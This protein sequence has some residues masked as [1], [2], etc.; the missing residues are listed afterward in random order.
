ML[1]ALWRVALRLAYRSLRVWWWLRQPEAHG[2]YVAVWR[3]ERL[4]LIRNSYRRGET[5]PCGAIARG[6]TPRAAARRELA[7]EVG[8]RV[9][10]ERLVDAGHHSV[11]FESKLDHASFFE[12]GLE[13]DEEDVEIRVDRRE[14]VWGEFVVEDELGRR[15]LVPHVRAYLAARAARSQSAS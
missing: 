8:I 13:A 5:V 2:A 9:P 10:E 15:P 6:E 1:D 14:V 7:E 4:L 12:L 3:G 11:E